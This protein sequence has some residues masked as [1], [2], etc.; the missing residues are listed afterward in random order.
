MEGRRSVQIVANA[1]HTWTVQP[2]DESDGKDNHEKCLPQA[3]QSTHHKCNRRNEHVII[4]LK[5]ND[6]SF[7]ALQIV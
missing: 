5:V 7:E 3:L 2:N 6:E 4:Y 1:Y